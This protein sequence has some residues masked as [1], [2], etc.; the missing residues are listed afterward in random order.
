MSQF[1]EAIQD[2][3]EVLKVIP[4]HLKA[5]LLKARA[6]YRLRK[7]GEAQSLC[8]GLIALEPTSRD[9]K[10]I[11]ESATKR[12]QETISGEFDFKRMELEAK[13]HKHPRLDYADFVGP[14]KIRQSYP[15]SK[16]R[17]LFAT[18]DIDYGELVICEKD[19]MTGYAGE[20]KGV[21]FIALHVG[22][23]VTT[24]VLTRTYRPRL[25]SC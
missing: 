1:D 6:L 11:L 4:N 17:G 15:S 9:G 13:T 5:V 8:H 7:F 18:R 12:I 21:T 19:F 23:S 2:C 10:N 20:K 24:W 22:K 3:E 14:I 25:C 16:G